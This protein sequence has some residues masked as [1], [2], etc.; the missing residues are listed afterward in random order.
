MSS[1]KFGLMIV[2]SSP[3]GAG[4]TTLVKLLSKKDNFSVSVSHTTRKPREQEK[5]GKDYF[6]VEKNDFENA[7]KVIEE[8]RSHI[9]VVNGFDVHK[10]GLGDHVKLCGVKIP[11][12]RGLL[13]H[14]DADVALHGGAIQR[15]A[16]FLV[17]VV[18]VDS[19]I[20]QVLDAALAADAGASFLQ[21]FASLLDERL[22]T[23]P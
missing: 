19:I 1:T 8:K 20:E 21:V 13:G 3:S 10:F 9:H 23:P 18:R 4:K 11:F 12:S 22:R 7:L 14:S 17:L 2:L 15:R 5:N 16:A 6:F